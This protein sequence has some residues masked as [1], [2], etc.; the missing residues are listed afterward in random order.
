MGILGAASLRPIAASWSA[1]SL[2]KMP[3]WAGTQQIEA[4]VALASI[5]ACCIQGWL[6]FPFSI[7]ARQL[8]ESEKTTGFVSLV[9]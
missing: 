7:E 5:S 6:E 8:A 9:L 1:F 4:F 2:P 3:T